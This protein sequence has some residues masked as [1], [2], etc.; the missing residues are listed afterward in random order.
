MR[1]KLGDVSVK[2]WLLRWAIGPAQIV[3]GII[4]MLSLGMIYI[5]LALKVSRVL[6]AHR[7]SLSNQ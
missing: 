5:G 3:D 6:A 7:I 2:A 1:I 4:T